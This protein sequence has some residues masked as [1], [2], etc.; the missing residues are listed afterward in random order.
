MGECCSVQAFAVLCLA[1]REHVRKSLETD[2]VA[3]VQWANDEYKKAAKENKKVDKEVQKEVDAERQ[4]VEDLYTTFRH[5]DRYH[6]FLN[7]EMGRQSWSPDM[8]QAKT[9]AEQMSYLEEVS[10]EIPHHY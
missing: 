6:P 5:F 4:R 10:R 1:A 9:I 2:A 3:C 7:K 8:P